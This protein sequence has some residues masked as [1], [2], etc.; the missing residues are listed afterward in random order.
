MIRTQQA[1]FTLVELLI[2][3]LLTAITLAGVY[4]TLIVQEKSYEAARHMLGDQEA[5][6][7][8]IAIL[9]SELREVGAVGGAAIGGSDIA[10][11]TA[12]SITF[13][14][15]RKLGIV[16][17]LSR[18]DR[19]LLVWPVGE[20]VSAGDQLLFLVDG[21]TLRYSDDRWDTT[22]VSNVSDASNAGCASAWPG[23]PLQQLKIDNAADLT[24]VY[25][26]APIR[27]YEWVTYALYEFGSLGWG[28]GR[29]RDSDP[30]NYLAGTFAPKGTGL[31]FTYFDS[32]GNPTTDPNMVSRIQ[33][34]MVTDPQTSTGVQASVMTSNLF[35]RNN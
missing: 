8:G 3:S 20:Q 22:Y 26:G 29:S 23:Q 13:R 14:A 15:Q 30:P 28:L 11:A 25:R 12:D 33:I 2:V 4:Q 35:L 21:D 34:T 17:D 16:C 7:T 5:L 24:G 9:E 10:A 31:Q 1:G 32:G 6:R 27:T 19:W 18:N